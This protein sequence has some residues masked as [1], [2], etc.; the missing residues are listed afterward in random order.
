MSSVSNRIRRCLIG[1]EGVTSLEFALV[2]VPFLWLMFGIFDIGRYFFT[3]QSMVTLMTA[4]ERCVIVN[5]NQQNWP[6]C[7]GTGTLVPLLDPSLVSVAISGP[8]NSP[9]A[10]T[11]IQ[12][13]VTYQF[14]AITP[15]LGLLSGPLTETTT[16]SY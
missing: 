13:T 6:G 15:G 14:A 12:V 7:L 9:G 4:A 8:S 2:F 5:P 10:V 16:Y 3:V 11:Q 1:R